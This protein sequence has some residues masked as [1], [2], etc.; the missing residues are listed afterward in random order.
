MYIDFSQNSILPNKIL[1]LSPIGLGKY[2]PGKTYSKLK[3]KP[4]F[5]K[6]KHNLRKI[7]IYVKNGV[8]TYL[9]G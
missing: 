1:S 2:R 9:S 6:T 7:Y 5:Q 3:K 8:E 4:S